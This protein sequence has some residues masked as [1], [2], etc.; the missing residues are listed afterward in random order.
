MINELFGNETSA[1][2]LLY[3]QNYGEGTPS[4]ISKSFGM[5]KM[6]V[7]KQL[8]RLEDAG[9]LVARDV[10][11]QRMFSFN[12]RMIIL[13]EIKNLL[14]KYLTTMPDDAFNKTFAER[15]RPRR[16]GKKL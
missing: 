1:Q 8:I 15:R 9:I 6:R 11:N 4:G 16:T 2:I 3:I 13:E 10:G 12:T 5:G 7:Y 14:Q